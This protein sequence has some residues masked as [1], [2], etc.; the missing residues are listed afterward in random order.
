[1]LLLILTATWA[2]ALMRYHIAHS[3]AVAAS[4]KS[5]GTIKPGVCKQPRH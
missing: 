5:T 3:Y 2:G 4:N 1:M